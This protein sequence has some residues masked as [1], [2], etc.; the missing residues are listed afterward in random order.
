LYVA[1]LS[2]PPQAISP[3]TTYLALMSYLLSYTVSHS[4]H[5]RIVHPVRPGNPPSEHH[6]PGYTELLKL[7]NNLTA[8]QQQ[9]QTEVEMLRQKH[10]S[11]IQ[12]LTTEI[13]TCTTQH[14]QLQ[15][16]VQSRQQQM[17]TVTGDIRNMTEINGR[18]CV[19][20]CVCARVCMCVC[21]CVCVCVHVRVRM[22]VR[23]FVW[24][25][26]YVRVRVRVRVLVCACACACEA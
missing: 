2:R 4:W 25:C 10:A 14:V 23:V 6:D 18:L 22:R 20:V 15:A 17:T 1:N 19:W 9:L 26:V 7:V 11:H 21:V 24:V 8:Q 13:Q 5:V 16:D 12:N 3:S